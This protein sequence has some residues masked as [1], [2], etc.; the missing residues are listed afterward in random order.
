MTA[1]TRRSTQR[2]TNSAAIVAV[3]IH[4]TVAS[5][6]FWSKIIGHLFSWCQLWHRLVW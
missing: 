6:L 4:K 1:A 3:F 2:Q 5:L